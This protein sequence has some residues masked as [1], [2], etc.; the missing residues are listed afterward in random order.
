M[1]YI[2]WLLVGFGLATAGGVTL[3]V[4]LNIIPAGLSFFDYIL[5]VMDRPE[6]YLFPVGLLII[7]ITVLLYPSE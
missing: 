1:W 4:Y 6:C 7:C 5:F 2:F 3:I